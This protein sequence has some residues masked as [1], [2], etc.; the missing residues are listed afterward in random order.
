LVP[1]ASGKPEIEWFFRA[2]MLAVTPVLGL[3]LNSMFSEIMGGLQGRSSNSG[4]RWLW[5]ERHRDTPAVL[6]VGALC[7][8][9]ALTVA[10][11]GRY[12]Q[13]IAA[14]MLHSP[15]WP[16]AWLLCMAVG[17]VL[18]WPRGRE[19]ECVIL[20]VALLG[21]SALMQTQPDSEPA[22]LAVAA[23][24]A[25]LWLALCNAVLVQRQ[26]EL[27]ALI[28]AP[29]R[30]WLPRTTLGRVGLVVG[31]KFVAALAI[32][33]LALTLPL[34]LL[35]NALSFGWVFVWAGVAAAVTLSAT[36]YLG[37]NSA[38]LLLAAA[39]FRSP[40]SEKPPPRG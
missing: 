15:S 33:A 22:S 4:G 7:F 28:R 1:M 11:L 20:P 29:W 23:S 34:M 18:T 6:A 39:W 16:L 8:A 2:F 40:A 5:F 31:I 26:A 37:G 13:G 25:A 17:G 9:A 35:V 21:G 12:G 30:S 14:L 24:G 3:A 19:W 38:Q 10:L 36:G 27:M 32:V